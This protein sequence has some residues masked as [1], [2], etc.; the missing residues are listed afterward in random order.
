MIEG[1]QQQR[2]QRLHVRMPCQIDID[3]RETDGFSNNLSATG[4]Y[5]CVPHEALGAKA[6]AVGDHVPLRFRLPDQIKEIEVG[7]EVVWVVPDGTSACAEPAIGLGVR[8]T[9]CSEEATKHLTEF[10]HDFRHTVMV[11]TSERDELLPVQ[12]ALADGYRVISCRTAE[13]AIEKLAT[14]T[15]AVLVTDQHML[16]TEAREPFHR[17]LQRLPHSQIIELFVGDR[18]NADD[19]R[20][21]LA[22]GRLVHHVGVPIDVGE[23]QKVVRRAVDIHAIEMEKE[24]LRIELDRANH[25]LRREN[26][27]LRH[28]VPGSHGFE[29]I[30]GHSVSLQ[31][32]LE[33]LERVRQTDVTVHIAG[34]TGTGKELVARALHANG[35]RAQGPFVA[36]N[37]AGLTETLLQSTLFGH[38]RG[39]FTGADRDRPG[40]FQ[41]A[42]GG[43]LFLD[44]VA[45]LSPTTQ[46]VLLRALE[47][48]EITPVGASEP[49][50]VD[51]R[52]ISATHQD[53]WERV[54]AGQFRDDLHF[55]LM[56]VT[57]E[58][59]PLRKRIGDIPLLTQHFLEL[60]S[61]HYDKHILGF[62]PETM[63][64]LERY[65]WPGNIRELENEVERVVV[66][67]DPDDKILP[68]LLS[69]HILTSVGVKADIGGDKVLPQPLDGN[70]EL[71]RRFLS[72]G[73][74][75]DDVLN[76]LQSSILV[77]ALTQAGGN[78]SRAAQQLG[79]PRQTLHSRMR[80]YGL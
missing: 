62:A 56:V 7:T 57:V 4:M 41:Q 42:H 22:L 55:R 21:F 58:L 65:T 74:S 5:V 54:R 30:L 18:P 27:Y 33:Q 35:P 64:I 60:H 34:E 19:Q 15:V 31:R 79:I 43:T 69:E 53:L 8:I 2:S 14:E 12:Q 45:E 17:L 3:G 6:P 44:E 71:A 23:L 32:A 36:Q 38:R 16:D 47:F 13:E 51:V 76:S 20:E 52:I 40:V 75:L 29:N 68:E 10:V 28:R 78:Q 39:A 1:E 67:A 73:R 63:A 24:L 25:K 59:P 37:C 26:A 46:A 61:Q 50:S 48:G 77:E 11:L 49:V 9:S 72:S 70:I 66:L 80:R